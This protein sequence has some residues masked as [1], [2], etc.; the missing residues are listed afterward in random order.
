MKPILPFLGLAA[1]LSL[2]GLTAPAGIRPSPPRA[3]V[4]AP[5]KTASQPATEREAL[6]S[7]G[8]AE[9]PILAVQVPARGNGAPAP[10]Q[11]LPATSEGVRSPAPSGALQ[12]T[13]RAALA[14]RFGKLSSWQTYWY[15]VAIARGWTEQGTT[16]LT[17][18]G[19]FDHDK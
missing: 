2:H 1:A 8:G 7:P 19:P 15:T 17:G 6:A 9:Q 14:G 11:G 10:A 18:Y 12:I 16:R 3:S 13:A 4:S 5:S